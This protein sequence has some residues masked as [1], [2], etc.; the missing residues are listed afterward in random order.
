MPIDN[1]K[2][3]IRLER[4]ANCARQAWFVGHTMESV[5]HKHEVSW[6]LD[7]FLHVVCVAR[8][9]AAISNSILDKPHS[10]HFEKLGVDVDCDDTASKFGNFQSEPA[11]AGA[12]IDNLHVGRDSDC[13]EHIA[14][15]RPQ[16]FP[17]ARGRLFSP[18]KEASRVIDHSS[19]CR[20]N[21]DAPSNNMHL[22]A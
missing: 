8:D 2:A 6:V 15:H 10:S 14:W 3:S 13:N 11:V 22:L 1:R 18:F 17:P 5:C 19:L 4:I 20:T 16:S 12:K 7:Q 9:E 21:D